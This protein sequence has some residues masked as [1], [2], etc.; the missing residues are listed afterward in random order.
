MES[1]LNASGT[2]TRTIA[3][4]KTPKLKGLGKISTPTGKPP[5]PQGRNWLYTG[6]SANFV[7][8]A[9]GDKTRKV[10]G[11]ITQTWRL[12]GRR[13]WDKD[14]Y[15]EVSSVDGNALHGNAGAPQLNNHNWN[16]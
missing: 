9:R 4:D 15:G 12:S 14:I 11:K 2:W 13:G 7:S 8:P 16:V 10:E 6:F 5:T 1:Y 3:T